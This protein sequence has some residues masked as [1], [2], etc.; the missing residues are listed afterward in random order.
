MSASLQITSLIAIAMVAWLILNLTFWRHRNQDC[1]R[2]NGPLHREHR[3]LLE[4]ML[5]KV[6]VYPTGHY[7]CGKC[8]WRGL[9]RRDQHNH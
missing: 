6:L 4:H 5:G 2:C 9:L 8:T 7:K 1:P 3:S